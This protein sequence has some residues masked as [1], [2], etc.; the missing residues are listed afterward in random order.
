MKEEG[1]GLMTV[2]GQHG[3]VKNIALPRDL[4]VLE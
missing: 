1:R 4:V 3:A 2:E